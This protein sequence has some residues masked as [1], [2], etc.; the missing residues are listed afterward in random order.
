MDIEEKNI[1]E[2]YSDFNSTEISKDRSYFI[3]KAVKVEFLV[4]I[5]LSNILGISEPN[6]S[7][8]FGDTTQ[9]L[10]F[11]AKVT[12]L[13]DLDFIDDNVK[14]KLEIFASVRNKF[15]SWR[16]YPA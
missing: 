12:L 7:K 13:D 10:S 14:A 3:D 5:L 9:S 4:N 16:E 8:S 6:K 11:M 15:P 1:K 2:T